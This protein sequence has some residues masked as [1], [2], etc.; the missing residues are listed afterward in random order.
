MKLLHLIRHAKSS[1]S[2]PELVDFDRP[3]KKRG[4]SDALLMAPVAVAAGWHA[5]AV[6]CSG[7]NRAR[8]TIEQW[9]GGL[10]QDMSQV[11]YLDQLY[12]FD[13]EDL[14]DWLCLQRDAELTIVGHNPALHELIEWSTAQPLEKFP[15]A[16]YCQ[17]T[18]DIDSW[19]KI[20]RGGG[21]LQSLITPKMLKHD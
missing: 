18:F 9:C 1:W 14:L 3:L 13:Y 4:I 8:Q 20:C 19:H 17:L 10:Q 21:T 7:A 12:T 2:D 6:Y 5:D 11:H 15:T 16:A